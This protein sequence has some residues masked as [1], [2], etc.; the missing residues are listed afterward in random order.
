MEKAL[1]VQAPKIILV[2]NHPSGDVTPSISDYGITER[3]DEAAKL[4]GI[5][6]VDHVIIGNNRYMSIVYGKEYRI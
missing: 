4:M 3:V 2:H 6:L 1:K 5:E